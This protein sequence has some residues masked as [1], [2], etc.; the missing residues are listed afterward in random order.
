[1]KSRTGNKQ[2]G[3]KGEED[4]GLAPFSAETTFQRTNRCGFVIVSIRAGL[5]DRSSFSP[6]GFCRHCF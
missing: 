6:G 2:A 3:G 4:L 5:R 1:M